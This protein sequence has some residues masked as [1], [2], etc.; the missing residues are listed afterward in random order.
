MSQSMSVH[1]LFVNETGAR[2]HSEIE[3]AGLCGYA[4]KCREAL[5]WQQAKP[6]RTVKTWAQG[7]LRTTTVTETLITNL[8]RRGEQIEQQ[9]GE[10]SHV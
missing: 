5:E 2:R 7:L 10:V 4:D 1:F 3:V 8:R 6:D 9:Y